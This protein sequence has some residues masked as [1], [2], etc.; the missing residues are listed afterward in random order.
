MRVEEG[1]MEYTW[2]FTV[3]VDAFPVLLRGLLVTVELWVLAFAIGLSLG[4]AVSLGD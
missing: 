4:F 1:A 2:D 3:I